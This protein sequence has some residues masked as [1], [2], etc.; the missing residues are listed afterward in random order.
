VAW[1]IEFTDEFGEWWEELSL[2][3]QESVRVK[4]ELLAELG[5]ALTRPHADTIHGSRLQ[6][7]RELRIQHEGRPYRVSMYSIRDGPACF[8]SAATRQA[9]RAGMKILFRKR[10]PSMNNIC[11]KSEWRSPMARNFDELRAKM[12]PDS[13]ARVAARVKKELAMM[14]LHQLRQAREMTQTRLAEVLEMDQGNISKLEKRAD[15]YLST[16]RS[17]VEAMGGSLEI[18]AVFPDGAVK[19]D[20]LNHLP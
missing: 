5:P 17:Y 15:M 3:E 2:G 8:S 14:P 11:T 13:Q 18:R 10:K 9:I 20:L 4:V 7:L 1:N 12:P 6:N 19:I 16:L